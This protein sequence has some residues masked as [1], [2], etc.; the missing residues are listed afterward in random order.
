MFF[1]KHRHVFAPVYAPFLKIFFNLQKQSVEYLS[2]G[3]H[4]GMAYKILFVEDD[5]LF[6]SIITKG[7]EKRGLEVWFRNRLNGL[8]EAIAAFRPNI[9]VLDLE[10]GAENSLDLLPALRSAYPS[11][12]I[13]FESSHTDGPE[14][15]KCL[16]AG[17]T[18]YIKK[19]YQIEELG[20][21]IDRLLPLLP[22]RDIDC[23]V[24]GRFAL[25]V[26]NRD[27]YFDDALDFKLNPKEFEILRILLENL[28]KTVTRQKLLE[29]VWNNE[30]ADESLNNYFT[31]LR[32][33]LRKD[34]TVKIQ[35]I[36]GIGYSLVLQH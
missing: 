20:A 18:H 21:Y 25:N 5:L 14:I 23:H 17:V 11:L 3:K 24:F 7:L 8:S 19:P 32:R 31:N 35:T 15:E 10:V 30:L 27:L 22:S 16:K 4:R 28:G 33:Y 36:K 1:K 29:R 12:P 2:K 26:T 34:S 6:G 9:L 13:L